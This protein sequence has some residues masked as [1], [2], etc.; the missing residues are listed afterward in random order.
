MGLCEYKK[1][2]TIRV[3]YCYI[4]RVESILPSQPLLGKDNVKII[5]HEYLKPDSKR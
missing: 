4:S 1:F 3:I 2:D 5:V